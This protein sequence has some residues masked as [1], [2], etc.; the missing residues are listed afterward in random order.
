MVQTYKGNN[1]ARNFMGILQN[2]IIR[3]EDW[4]DPRSM[5]IM[6]IMQK[7]QCGCHLKIAVPRDSANFHNFC[8]DQEIQIQKGCIHHI[9]CIPRTGWAPYIQSHTYPV[10]HTTMEKCLSA[11]CSRWASAASTWKLRVTSIRNWHKFSVL[12]GHERAVFAVL[13]AVHQGAT[14]IA[15]VLL[16]PLD[17]GSR[18][19]MVEIRRPLETS[20]VK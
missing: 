13:N 4:V 8:T 7:V 17:L 10:H 6:H 3:R 20:W 14:H 16:Q 19:R 2:Y 12:I 18:T 11:M 5:H 9:H 1:L 15:H